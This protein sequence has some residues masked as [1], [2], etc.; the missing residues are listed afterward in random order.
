MKRGIREFLLKVWAVLWAAIISTIAGW[1]IAS[2]L[3]RSGGYG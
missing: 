3:T 1:A 2:I